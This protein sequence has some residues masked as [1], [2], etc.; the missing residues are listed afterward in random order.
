MCVYVL[1]MR[2][3]SECLC[4]HV[5]TF[6]IC[7][8]PVDL[9]GL[10]ALACE[11]RVEVDPDNTKK[12]FLQQ[13]LGVVE[14]LASVDPSC[15]ED[16]PK[17]SRDEPEDWF[18]RL[19]APPLEAIVPTAIVQN[20]STVDAKVLVVDDNKMNCNVLGMILK[21]LKL[22]EVLYAYDGREALEVFKTSVRELDCVLMDLMMPNMDGLESTLAIR[23]HERMHALPPVP[24]VAVTACT[25]NPRADMEETGKDG[26]SFDDVVGATAA[27]G[28]NMIVSKPVNVQKVR[29][30]LQRAAGL[31]PPST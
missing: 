26:A 3:R 28:M 6:S 1:Y 21:K 2:A 31:I 9:R 4:V 10:S 12:M 30:L 19:Q 14:L 5:P 17:G 7:A 24:I 27:V 22:K 29:D 25:V 8:S 23:A 13:W 16:P 15:L 20:R 18:T 11:R